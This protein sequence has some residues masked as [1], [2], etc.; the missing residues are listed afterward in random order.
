M[1][2]NAACANEKK[3]NDERDGGERIQDRI[4]RRQK[5]QSRAGQIGGRVEPRSAACVLR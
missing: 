5:R 3:S 2:G 4:K 1:R